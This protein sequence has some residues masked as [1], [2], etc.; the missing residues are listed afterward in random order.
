MSFISCFINERECSVGKQEGGMMTHVND[1]AH[2]WCHVLVDIA[3]GN[4]IAQNNK[5][6]QEL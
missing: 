5:M 2:A 1:N 3:S 6:F 4:T